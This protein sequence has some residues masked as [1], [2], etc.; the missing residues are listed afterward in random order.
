MLI[1]ES[2]QLPLR[3]C[4]IG[5]ADRIDHD[6]VD[7]PVAFVG[8]DVGISEVR[9]LRLNGDVHRLEGRDRLRLSALGDLEIVLS[10]AAHRFTLVIGDDGIDLN[11]AH[12]GTE[13]G[14]RF[15]RRRSRLLGFRSLRRCLSSPAGCLP[16]ATGPLP[17]DENGS[18]GDNRKDEETKWPHILS[19]YCTD[20]RRTNWRAK[21][22]L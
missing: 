22:R 3:E 5:G 1:E 19:R 11:R 7:A 15:L 6:Q 21:L 14:D 9:L 10:E 16:A 13:G 8:D 2:S 17:G 12:A 20:E 18:R 4:R